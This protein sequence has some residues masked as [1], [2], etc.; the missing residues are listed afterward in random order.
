MNTLTLK[1]KVWKYG[2]NLSVYYFFPPIYEMLGIAEQPEELAKHFLEEVDPHLVR[3]VEGGDVL[4]AGKGFGQ[5]KHHFYYISAFQELGFGGFVA[6]SFH[7]QFQRECIDRGIPAI[8]YPD[9][10]SKVESGDLLELNLRTGKGNV[11]NRSVA[12]SLV[13]APQ[14]LLSILAAGGLKP[15][16]LQKL[17]SE[18]RN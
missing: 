14:V 16:T 3:Q 18:S 6:E 10:P 8:A 5:G 11:L 15:Y 2:D 4:V 7:P 12:I 9:L 17:A 1:G 13:P